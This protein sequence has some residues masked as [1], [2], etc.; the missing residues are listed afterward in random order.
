MT[1]HYHTLGVNNDAS[2]E[3]ITKAYRKKAMKNHPD[4]QGGSEEAFYP[5]QLAYSVLS[6]PE[7]RKTYDETGLDGT[8]SQDDVIHAQLGNLFLELVG[9]V[10]DV[11]MI[12]IAAE[13]KKVL[14]ISMTQY[15]MRMQALRNEIEKRNKALKR[16]TRKDGE[17]I[18]AAMLSANI[19]AL[20]QELAAKEGERIIGEKLLALVDEYVYQVEHPGMVTVMRFNNF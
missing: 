11:D 9:K 19:E 7:K 1:D 8:E 13:M 20:E 18:L 10:S 12:D 14:N 6:D 2:D 17:N 4:R 3:E 15:G 16:I 5:I